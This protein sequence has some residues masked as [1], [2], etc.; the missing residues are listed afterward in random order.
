MSSNEKETNDVNESRLAEEG[1]SSCRCS[2]QRN[3]GHHH[4][5]PVISKRRNWTRQENKIVMECYLLSPRLEGIESV[6]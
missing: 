4:V 6:W 5:N 3:T 1:P 2:L